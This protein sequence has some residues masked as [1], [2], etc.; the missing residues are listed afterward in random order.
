[1]KQL[2][3]A[4]QPCRRVRM[5]AYSIFRERLSILRGGTGRQKMKVGLTPIIAVYP[6]TRPDD[7]F[8]YDRRF[9]VH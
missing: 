3:R 8:H 5:L 2:C 1:M 7:G 6:S 9:C 4:A